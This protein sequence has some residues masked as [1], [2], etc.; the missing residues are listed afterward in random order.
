MGNH[1]ITTTGADEGTNKKMNKNS[2]T[3]I[4]ALFGNTVFKKQE[5]H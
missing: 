3:K 1:N 2:L 5:L 4:T